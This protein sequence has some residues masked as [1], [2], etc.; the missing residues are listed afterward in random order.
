VET[1]NSE[2]VTVLLVFP[3]SSLSALRIAK[4]DTFNSI[5][6]NHGKANTKSKFCHY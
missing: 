2:I 1:K 5:A 4:H 3:L 6:L